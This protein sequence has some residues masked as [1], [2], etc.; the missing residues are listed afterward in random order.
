MDEV[1]SFGCVGNGSSL[2]GSGGGTVS[3]KAL[4]K[5]ENVTTDRHCFFFKIPKYYTLDL[6]TNIEP[7]RVES[8]I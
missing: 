8:T 6:Y 4:K 2:A 5:R 7:S 3:E 1:S